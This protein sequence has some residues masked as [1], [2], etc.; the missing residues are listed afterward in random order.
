MKLRFKKF[1]LRFRRYRRRLSSQFRRLIK[2]PV[3]SSIVFFLVLVAATVGGFLVFNHGSP[4]FEPIS[5][6]IVIISHDNKKQV[7]PTREATIG[8]LL[9]K[10]NIKLGNG[11]RVEPSVSTPIAQDNLRVNIYRAVPVEIV[12]GTQHTLALSAATTSR[13]LA[14]QAGVNLYPEDNVTTARLSSSL[15]KG[16]LRKT[17]VVDRA[18]PILLNIYGTPALVRTHAKTV[19]EL[20]SQKNIKLQENDRVQPGAETPLTPN[21][22]VSLLH[23][24]VEVVTEFSVIP[25]PVQIVRDNSLSFGTQAV[26][27]QGS[28]GQEAT[29]YQI[30]KENNIEVSRT[31]LQKVVIVQPVPQIVAQGQAVSIPADKQAVMAQAGIRASDYPYVDYIVSH[32]SGWCPTKMQGQIGYC[33]GYAP[34]SFPSYLGYGLVQATPGTKMSSAGGDWQTNPVTQL[35]WAT[36]YAVGR[37]GSWSGAYYYWQSHH[38]W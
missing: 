7:V 19:G 11:D 15:I 36:G 10:L 4:K 2:H 8:S 32:E 34:A 12:D 18:T 37:Y 29:T 3:I 38:Y 13:S 16:G 24:G 5:S 9:G 22:Q 17:I 28:Q 31:L 30:V 26:R 20:M 1:N 35:R 27:Q 6:Y 25:A 14:Q 23:K 33:P 21:L